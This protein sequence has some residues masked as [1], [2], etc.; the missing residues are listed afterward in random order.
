VTKA[1]G[2]AIDTTREMIR[3]CLILA[4]IRSNSEAHMALLCF[5]V[6]GDTRA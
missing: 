5:I 2:A 3:H 1:V 4:A 6:R